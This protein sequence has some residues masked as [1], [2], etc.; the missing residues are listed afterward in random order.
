MR[1]VAVFQNDDVSVL[2]EERKQNLPPKSCPK[3]NTGKARVEAVQHSLSNEM[4]RKLD[5]RSILVH[6]KMHVQMEAMFMFFARRRIF[7]GHI[8]APESQ[9]M[10]TDGELL[11]QYR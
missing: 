2:L 11:Y 5:P 9:R 1:T 10:G 8:A 6:Q 7:A 4:K 3:S